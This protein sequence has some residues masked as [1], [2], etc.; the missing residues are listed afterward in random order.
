MQW[1]PWFRKRS[2]NENS[3][4][5]TKD[6]PP[7]EEFLWLEGRRHIKDLPYLMPT[8]QAE[9]NRLDF[10]HYLVRYAMQ[11]NYI[12]PLDNP[13]GIL[14]VGCGTGRWAHEIALA[15]PQAKVFGLDINTIE[16]KSEETI[17][18]NYRFVRGNVLEEL[19]FPDMTFDFL[20]QRFLHVAIPVTK[21]P[22]VV[23]ELIRVTRR[24]GWIELAE[25]DQIIQRV[26][27][28]MAQLAQWGAQWSQQRG[29][30]TQ[31]CSRL[32]S[33]LQ[34]AGLTNI[35]S[36]RVD[37]PLGNWAGRIG[38]MTATDIY[39]Y[40]RAIKPMLVKQLGI[41]AD[42]YDKLSQMM[43]QEWETYHSFFSFYIT[44]AQRTR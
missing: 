23:S 32:P 18:R 38:N 11:C 12:A 21:W 31:V 6:Q 44:C 40:N 19:P 42:L 14:D 20:H 33:L 43:R 16:T 27:P 17:P 9:Y 39:T 4:Q 34:S 30:D 10:Q 28:A 35:Q 15:F 22:H 24:G 8:D 25:S 5:A 37:L 29:I 7:E 26:G 2:S 3:T 36:Y 13:H 1:L 41:Q